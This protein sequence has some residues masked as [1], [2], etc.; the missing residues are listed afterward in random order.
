MLQPHLVRLRSDPS[1]PALSCYTGQLTDRSA[2]LGYKLFEQRFQRF[3]AV[4]V[5]RLCRNMLRRRVMDF[6]PVAAV[7]LAVPPVKL[8][9]PDARYRNLLRR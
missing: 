6:L 3:F 4:R 1:G 5:K 2:A 9:E 8:A 7:V